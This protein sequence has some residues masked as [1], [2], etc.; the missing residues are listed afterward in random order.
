MKGGKKLWTLWGVTIP[1]IDHSTLWKLHIRALDMVRAHVNGA[2][3]VILRPDPKP[4]YMHVRNSQNALYGAGRVDAVTPVVLVEG[5]FDA[6]SVRQVLGDICV[7]VAT[8]Q[9]VET[10]LGQPER[11][12]CNRRRRARMDRSRIRGSLQLRVNKRGTNCRRSIIDET[13]R[14]D[15]GP[16]CRASKVSGRTT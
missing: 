13:E 14:L 1:W 12:A 8:S 5:A 7:A 15:R 2:E 10:V 4:K 6:L 9:T 16:E 11:H 3:R